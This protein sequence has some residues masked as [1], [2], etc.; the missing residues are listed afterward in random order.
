MKHSFSEQRRLQTY[1]ANL[2]YDHVAGVEEG[3]NRL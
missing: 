2:V 3:S 1:R